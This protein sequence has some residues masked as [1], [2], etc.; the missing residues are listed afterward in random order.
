MSNSLFSSFIYIFSLG[1][2]VI[3]LM[4]K[5]EWFQ[6]IDN[7]S[8]ILIPSFVVLFAPFLVAKASEFVLH[9]LTPQSTTILSPLLSS[10]TTIFVF[11]AGRISVNSERKQVDANKEIEQVNLLIVKM[12][13][14]SK[15]LSYIENLLMSSIRHI[16]ENPDIYKEAKKY[17]LEIESLYEKLSFQVE[18]FKSNNT[19][20]SLLYINDIKNYLELLSSK[21]NLHPQDELRELSKLRV[22]K[23][24]CV[25]NMIDL[26][27]KI[28]Q[29]SGDARHYIEYLKEYRKEFVWYKSDIQT[30]TQYKE[31][32]EYYGIDTELAAE[33]RIKDIFRRL[34]VPI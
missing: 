2:S 7:K 33:E 25:E 23:V 30:N 27:Q 9:D 17:K 10:I 6:K 1:I 16:N 22:L 8:G 5:L 11:I 20:T 15:R 34:K 13:T 12:A 31:K 21:E 18:Y 14:V 32:Y 24:Q 19:L 28:S 26:K 3:W 29:D 4:H